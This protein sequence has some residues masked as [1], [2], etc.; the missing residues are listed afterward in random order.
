MVPYNSRMELRVGRSVWNVNIPSERLVAL[1]RAA[2]QPVPEQPPR[3]LVRAALEAPFGFEPMRRAVAP[4]DRV[5]VVLDTELPHASDLLAGV[6]DHLHTAGVPASDVTVLTPPGANHGWR[7]DLPPEFS[8]VTAEVHDPDN[9]KAHAYLATTKGGRRVYLN[10]TLVEADF[11]VLL[12]GR[13]YDPLLDYGGAETAVFPQLSNAETRTELGDQFTT[14]PPTPIPSDFRAEAIEVARLLG[15]P[16]LVQ[17]INGEGDAIQEVVAGLLDSAAEGVKRQDAR[18]RATVTDEVETVIATI[19]GD[20]DRVTFMDVAKA[21]V[22]AARVVQSEGRIVV[23]SEGVP[24][25]GEGANLLRTL[26]GP[27]AARRQLDKLQPD[28]WAAAY[29]WCFPTKAASVFLAT[30]LPDDTVEELFATPVRD[31]AEVQRLLDMG[32]RVAVIP[33]AHRTVATIE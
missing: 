3:E 14:D 9:A 15:T 6:L 13:G 18:W 29:L 30:G 24:P 2:V 4:G 8:A 26:D 33:D 28:D 32:G 17:V 25:L 11:T 10:R 23:L 16:F 1:R 20:P 21:A 27:R 7:D 5:T 22:C 12:A 31:A 19:S